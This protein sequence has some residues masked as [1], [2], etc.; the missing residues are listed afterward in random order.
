MVVGQGD[1]K[2]TLSEEEIGRILDEALG[3][4]EVAGKRVLLIIPDG[5]RTAPIPL[6]FR[7]LYERLGTAAAFDVLIALGTHPPMSGEAINRRLGLSARERTEQFGRVRVFNHRWDLPE[8]FVE[9]GRI[10]PA[11]AE[12][13]T[14]GRL[15]EAVPIRINR[16][17]LDYDQ[18]IICGPTFPHEV[19]GFSGGNKYLFPG[20]SGPEIIHFFHWLGA[21]E[22]SMQVIGVKETPM[23]RVIDRAARFVDRPVLC[24]CLVVGAA[25][26][27]GLYVGPAEEAWSRAAD[28]SAQVHIRYVDEPFETVLSMPAPMYEDLW[29]AAKA[30]YKTEP[31]VADGGEVIIYQPT[32]G[33]I[34]YTH[35]ELIDQI[36][37]HVRDY[38]LAQMDRFR[39]IPKGVLAHSTHVKGVGTY[40]SARRREHPRIR[41]TLATAI[42]RARC[43]RVNLGYRDPASIDP[44]AWEGRAGVLVVPHAGEILYR[45]ARDAP[46]AAGSHSQAG[47]GA[48][49]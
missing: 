1:A 39:D 14:N 2:R 8:T 25:G 34:S 49:A 6:L 11:E 31:V 27:S 16:L 13:L 35:G 3:R 46:A 30:M 40:D 5:T 41:V 22:T 18:L 4:C 9:I 26:L 43:E 48:P 29:T 42:P 23:R 17:I 44:E 47:T 33:E 36:G 20:I 10:T 45:L 7:L 32:L 12:V 38:F 15:I 21:L 19:V 24:C 28:L 37:Y